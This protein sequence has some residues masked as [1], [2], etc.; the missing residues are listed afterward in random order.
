M[1]SPR[2]LIAPVAGA[3]TWPA[4]GAVLQPFVFDP[5]HP[6]AA[7]EHRGIDIGGDPG[8]TVLAPV[9]GTVTFAGTVPA[10]GKCVTITTADG[11][12][13]T[14]T[15]LGSLAVAKGATVAEGDGVGTIGPSGDAELPAALRA[16]R[17]PHRGGASGLRRPALASAGPHCAAVRAR[18]AGCRRA[19]R[20]GACGARGGTR[21]GRLAGTL[22]ELT[23]AFRASACARARS[24]SRACV[25]VGSGGHRTGER[26]CARCA[27][28]RRRPPA[29][30]HATKSAAHS[31]PVHAHAQAPATV[32]APRE[33]TVHA[34]AELRSSATRRPFRHAPSLHSRSIGQ[35]RAVGR[36]VRG[37]GSASRRRPF[38][39]SAFTMRSRP[40][41]APRHDHHALRTRRDHSAPRTRHRPSSARPSRCLPAPQVRVRDATCHHARGAGRP[42]QRPAHCAR[43][44]AVLLV[45]AALL[46]ARSPEGALGGRSYDGSQWQRREEDPGGAGLAVCG[47]PS[48]PGT[49]GGLRRPVRTCSPA[50]TG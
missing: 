24:D 18:A 42:V 15:H 6:Y 13:V 2:S 48:A 8:A 50:I 49:C 31:L 32:A 1:L 10:S 27:A 5:A 4:A 38:A 47:G 16:P 17:R 39:S 11:Y 37:R 43:R 36:H 46:A 29:A 41:A 35:R 26:A 12:A 34:E 20:T 30:V 3:W 40:C 9:A 22:G 23:V 14:L 21:T 28:G 19:G 7:G 33:S 45:L 44:P 25:R